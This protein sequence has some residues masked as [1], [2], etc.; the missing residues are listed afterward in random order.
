MLAWCVH[1]IARAPGAD[2]HA[3]MKDANVPA[4][5][6]S[7][8]GS[9]KSSLANIAQNSRAP[10]FLEAPH[11]RQSRVSTLCCHVSSFA[12]TERGCCK[13]EDGIPAACHIRESRKRGTCLSILVPHCLDYSRHL[14]AGGEAYPAGHAEF[15]RDSPCTLTKHLFRKA[16]RSQRGRN[17]AESSADAQTFLREIE[18]AERVTHQCI[19]SALQHNDVWHKDCG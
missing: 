14:Q 3:R 12:R 7:L 19:C 8:D 13:S 4:T 1:R 11:A 5:F 10:E 9:G 6:E 18:F 2:S 17:A 15:P 16:A